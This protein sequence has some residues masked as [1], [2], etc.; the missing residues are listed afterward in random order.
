MFLSSSSHLLSQ[1]SSKSIVSEPEPSH[2]NFS[3]VPSSGTVH[4]SS[5]MFDLGSQVSFNFA[6]TLRWISETL[7]QSR[8]AASPSLIDRDLVADCGKDLSIIGSE[9]E[10]MTSRDTSELFAALTIKPIES[11]KDGEADS[12]DSAINNVQLRSKKL[13]GCN[14][15]NVELHYCKICNCE[16]DGCYLF[17]CVIESSVLQS[18]ELSKCKVSTCDALE[19]FIANSKDRG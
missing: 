18:A 12:E 19:S 8:S 11:C 17:D 14:L 5:S 10:T 6:T 15:Q 4:L 16:L 3:N 9:D 7:L 13:R 2:V 1:S